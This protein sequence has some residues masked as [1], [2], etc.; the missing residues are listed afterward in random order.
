MLWLILC[1]IKGT[2][3]FEV[4]PS[5]INGANRGVFRTRVCVTL[6]PKF[7]L[8]I[9]GYFPSIQDCEASGWDTSKIYDELDTVRYPGT[10]YETS[11]RTWPNQYVCSKEVKSLA[12]LGGIANCP[13]RAEPGTPKYD[14]SVTNST[15]QDLSI[16]TYCIVNNSKVPHLEWKSS[17]WYRAPPGDMYGLECEVITSYDHS[18]R[19]PNLV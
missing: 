19:L 7:K 4:N 13:V 9:D 6:P 15:T 18:Y 2:P 3:I 16:A 8:A 10:L 17:T 1:I 14:R 12:A 11:G 5:L